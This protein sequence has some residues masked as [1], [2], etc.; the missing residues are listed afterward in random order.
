MKKISM[1]LIGTVAIATMSF[2]VLPK[3]ITHTQKVEYQK[4]NVYPAKG[5]STLAWYN[6][7]VWSPTTAPYDSKTYTTN[8]V[9]TKR[10][11]YTIY[12]DGPSGSGSIYLTSADPNFL[13]AGGVSISPGNSYSN[14]FTA[15]SNSVTLKVQRVSTAATTKVYFSSEY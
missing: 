11:L 7:P 2:T 13:P 12:H 10:V 3:F 15:S 4:T 8:V 9:A 14:N 6:H 5:L 1:F